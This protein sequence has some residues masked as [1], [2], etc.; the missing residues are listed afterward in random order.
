MGG[1]R[2]IPARNG[3]A[4]VPSSVGCLAVFLSRSAWRKKRWGPVVPWFVAKRLPKLTLEKDTYL[5]LP[6]GAKLLLKSIQH[7]LGVNWHTL[8]G[9]GIQK[10]HV[11]FAAQPDHFPQN[12]WAM[13]GIDGSAPKRCSSLLYNLE[14]HVVC[15]T[16]TGLYRATKGGKVRWGID[17]PDLVGSPQNRV[18]RGQQSQSCCDTGHRC[19]HSHQ[20]PLLFTLDCTSCVYPCST[21]N[22]GKWRLIRSVGQSYNQ[23]R[24]WES[25]TQILSTHIYNTQ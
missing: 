8:E 17:S 11:S 3:P 25:D 12:P 9:A 22:S 6:K 4:R 1:A 5:D 24:Y 13:R 7:L 14:S 2:E 20:I 19:K 18:C 16:T 21:T 23:D 10:K 15:D